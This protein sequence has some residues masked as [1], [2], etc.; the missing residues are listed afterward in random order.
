M[1]ISTLESS[2]EDASDGNVDSTMMDALQYHG[3]INWWS[4]EFPKLLA[5][6]TPTDGNCLL[7]SVAFF[8][9]DQSD[10]ELREKLNKFFTTNSITKLIKIRWMSHLTNNA[11]ADK[12]EISAN[13]IDSE[14]KDLIEMTALGKKGFH[15]S[16]E[17]VHVYGLAQMLKRSIIVFSGKMMLDLN[18]IPF[19][20][21]DIGGIYVPDLVPINENKDPILVGYDEGHFTA[22][23]VAENITGTYNIPIV[24]KDA[25][26]I[27]HRF[28]CP[29]KS[30]FDIE[31]YLNLTHI[32][33][34]PC[35]ITKTPAAAS[36]GELKIFGIF[37]TKIV[38]HS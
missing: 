5:V 35:V 26:H 28:G 17:S 8:L 22:L 20:P 2:D 14:W 16:L 21:I 7:H 9:N 36:E 27:E 4:E 31:K 3:A 13:Q 33:N 15:K 25:I 1:F 18:D 6:K 37:L 10:I 30:R 11:K 24:N 12:Y 34:I 29:L 19:V 32:N 23:K 38:I